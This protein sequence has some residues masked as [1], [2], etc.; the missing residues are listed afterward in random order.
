MGMV[1]SVLNNF[2]TLDATNGSFDPETVWKVQCMALDFLFLYLPGPRVAHTPINNEWHSDR[3]TT[4]K[5]ALRAQTRS[6]KHGASID[7]FAIYIFRYSCLDVLAT[8]WYFYGCKKMRA[9][10][11]SICSS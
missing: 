1:T 9:S 4:K 6:W 2:L 3:M 8:Q 7:A 11:R 10:S 5:D